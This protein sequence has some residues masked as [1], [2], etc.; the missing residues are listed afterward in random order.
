MTPMRNESTAER[1]QRVT[2][3]VLLLKLALALGILA[4]S[5]HI[6]RA[7]SGTAMMIALAIVIAFFAVGF[8]LVW[9][10]SLG[11][12]WARIL[13]LILVVIGTP[14]S[15]PGYIRDLKH[16]LA[17]PTLSILISL[18]QIIGTSLL[19]TGRANAWFRKWK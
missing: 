3:A 6:I 18:L 5:V 4:A 9:R 19:F 7:V 15:V 14:L 1:P 11:N 8:L 12:N 13:L 16:G 17:W 2:T 10:I